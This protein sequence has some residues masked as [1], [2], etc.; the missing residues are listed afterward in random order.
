MGRK[1]RDSAMK[2]RIS[3]IKLV[4]EAD[5]FTKLT[6]LE[7]AW[8][9]KRWS[10]KQLLKKQKVLLN[11]KKTRCFE[12]NL[13]LLKFDKKLKEELLKRK[14]NSKQPERTS[15]KPSIICKVHWNKKA[16]ERP[17]HCE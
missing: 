2:L 17:K 15:E 3:W 14:K 1:T 5:Q 12:H 4:K 13:S 9:L 10:F 8:K 11:K 6:K 16:R 7:N